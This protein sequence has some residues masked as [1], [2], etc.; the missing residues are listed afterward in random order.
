M[1]LARGLE[2]VRPGLASIVAGAADGMVLHGAEPEIALR[3]AVAA[4]LDVLALRQVGAL[5]DAMP[6]VVGLVNSIC[7]VITTA[8]AGAARVFNTW[9]SNDIAGERRDLQ[10]DLGRAA[11]NEQIAR[12]ETSAALSEQTAEIQ[13]RVQ[14]LLSGQD[15]EAGHSILPGALPLW[16]YGVI[17]VVVV[18]GLGTLG[19][20]A[21]K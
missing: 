10:F 14:R 11:A 17:G 9:A 16:A 18:G 2:S 6:P 21:F 13:D 8:V 12:A 3:H 15:T 4:S 20:Y 19:Y 5:G 7:G 1:A